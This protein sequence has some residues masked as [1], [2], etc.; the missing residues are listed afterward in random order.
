MLWRTMGYLVSRSQTT[1]SGTDD[2][3]LYGLLESQGR[4]L[5]VPIISSLT[6][7]G[8]RFAGVQRRIGDAR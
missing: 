4:N 5:S 3:Q 2:S 8:S 1:I 6:S 7:P